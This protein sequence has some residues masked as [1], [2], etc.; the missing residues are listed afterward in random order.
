MWR[1]H[2]FLV[3]RARGTASLPRHSTLG[4]MEQA[5]LTRLRWRLRGAWLW[6]AFAAL[7]LARGAAA[8]R[9]ADLGIGTARA[10]AGDPDRR[11]PQPDRRRGRRPA[12]RDGCCAAA[13]PTSRARSPPTTRPPGCC[14]RW[15]PGCS[16]PASPTTA[17]WPTSSEARAQQFVAVTGYVDAQAPE[18]HARLGQADTMRVE[19]DVY[20]T[21]VPGTRPEAVAVPVRGHAPG[22]AGRH[23]RP[24]RGAQP[25]LPATWRLRLGLAAGSST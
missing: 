13:G 6:P 16:R 15:R 14:W 20:R 23:A 3:R 12:R 21:C 9:T 10:R 24:R 8:Q 11:L 1:V 25:R 17:R 18:Y 7:D 5:R 19:R 4:G 22:A 2:P